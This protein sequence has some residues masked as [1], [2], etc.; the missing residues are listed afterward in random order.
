MQVGKSG[1]SSASSRGSFKTV[2]LTVGG[3]MLLRTR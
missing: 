3:F 1:S 2:T